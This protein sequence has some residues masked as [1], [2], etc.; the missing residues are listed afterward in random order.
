KKEPKPIYLENAKKHID[1]LIENSS[2]GYSGA[3]WGTGFKI[4]ISDT[5]IYDKSVPFSTNT[6]YVLEAL[7]EY[8]QITNDVAIF[9]VIKSIYDFYEKD[10]VVL[11]EDENILITSYGP[12]KD[13]IVTN[14]VSYTMFAYSIFYKLFDNKKYIAQKIEKMMNFVASVQ[15]E[16]GSWLYAPY[17]SSSFIDCF[18]SV[19]IL[20]NI[21]KTSRNIGIELKLRSEMVNSGYKYIKESF[22]DKNF[23]LF[24]RF[25]VSNK[26][27]LTKFDLYDNAEMLY[28]AKLTNDDESSISLE[29]NIKTHFYSNKNIY[30][31][32]D[33]FKMKKNKNTLRWAVMPYLLAKSL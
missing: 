20:K 33:M 7:Y 31:L 5:L 27:S 24:K 8:F 25:S 10:L 14:A 16:D 3:C 9:E 6:P 22:L 32:I 13:R 12:F 19:F 4:V 2:K 21:I 18:H 28:L 30:S 23:G 26:P 11:Q 17:D 1:W 15:R 29:K